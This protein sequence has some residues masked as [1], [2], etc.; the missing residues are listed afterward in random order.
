VK[1]TINLKI[2]VLATDG[3]YRKNPLFKT[4]FPPKAL[5]NGVLSF[6]TRAK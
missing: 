4:D 3:S 1:D 2:P 5:F 6:K